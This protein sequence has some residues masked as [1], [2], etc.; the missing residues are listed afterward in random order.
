MAVLRLIDEAGLDVRP[1]LL[2]AVVTEEVT[3]G[4]HGV[5]VTTLPVHAGAFEPRLD[6][7]LVGTL[8]HALPMGQPCWR[9]RGYCNCARRFLR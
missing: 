5:D 2:P 8:D 6:D 7:E 3:Q 9:K 1:F 4:E